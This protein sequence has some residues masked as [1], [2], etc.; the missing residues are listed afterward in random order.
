M[1]TRN[2][3]IADVSEIVAALDRQLEDAETDEERRHA[4]QAKLSAQR[5][6]MTILDSVPAKTD[7]E[8]A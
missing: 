2:T 4:A 5:L 6:R 8:V 7:G 1:R 3:R